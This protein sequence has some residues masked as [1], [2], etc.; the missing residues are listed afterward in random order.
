M[1]QRLPKILIDQ[2][3]AGEVIVRP[4]SVVKELVENSLDA[5][6]R[7]IAVWVG[8]AVR[9]ITV[10]DDGTGM[11]ADDA[12]LALE[13]HATSKIQSLADLD[14]LATRGFRGEALPSIAAV[15][16]LT[17]TTRRL[18][19]LAATRVV[20]EG[21]V[22]HSVGQVGAP[23]G[24]QVAVRDLFYNTPARRKF[25]KSPA[26]ELGQAA[27]IVVRQA[28][29][30][31]TVGFRFTH[32][33]NQ[34]FDLP[35]DQPLESRLCQLLSVG[36]DTLV[37]VLL[38][39]H[40]VRVRGFVAKPTES[41]R[42]RRHQFFFVNGR[43][44]THRTLGFSV[45][46]AFEGLLTTQR[47]P[48][49]ALFIQI[50]PDQVDV[51]VHPTK[52]EVR[53]ADEA[54]VCGLVHR[55]VSEAL[56]GANLMPQAR[57]TMPSPAAPPVESKPPIASNYEE[58]FQQVGRALNIPPAPYTPPGG[59][60][61]A[62]TSP[63]PTTPTPTFPNPPPVSLSPETAPA[64]PSVVAP[65]PVEP[66]TPQPAAPE[67]RAAF[68]A[69]SHPRALAQI[70]N[71]YIIAQTDNGL[72]LVDQHAAHERLLYL[73]AK[74]RTDRPAVQS[75]LVP[76]SVEVKPA[77]RPLMEGL[78]PVLQTMG[79]EVEA[80]GGTTFVVHSVPAAFEELDI[81]RFLADLLDEMADTGLP[82][83]ADRLHERVATSLACHAA[84][85][86]GQPLHLDEMQRLLDDLLAAR[87]A[88]TCP[89]GRPTMIL[90]TRDQLDR[91]FKRT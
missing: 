21:G 63:P 40:D 75:L 7:H 30:A 18:E 25:M 54:K 70:D 46:Q 76:I 29:S 61:A 77:D 58:L 78:I 50:P 13:R 16:R 6:A 34:Y 47:Y 88:Y 84:V 19:D 69:G 35:A 4:A 55:A 68:C 17:L 52:E 85:K 66:A 20:V 64:S 10:T 39:R 48:L 36:A 65:L 81:A 24:T 89:H 91:Q 73:R 53:F 41:R 5:H 44:I 74:D 37:E 31:A 60:P 11:S 28:L 82:R 23:P 27:R 8:N 62:K 67:D 22:V 59:P 86:A 45:E 43:P 90:L 49:F 1:I 38:E 9:D 57:L 3:A 80:F 51:N 15:S 26:T 87:L 33:Q 42:D 14:R 83:E 72:L 56:H 12:P 79:F 71:T 32:E 2:I